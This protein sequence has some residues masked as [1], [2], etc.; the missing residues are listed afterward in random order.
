MSEQVVNIMKRG[1]FCKL[2]GLDL[3]ERDLPLVEY[4]SKS[5]L[6]SDKLSCAPCVV[7]GEHVAY[8]KVCASENLWNRNSRH[9]LD[10]AAFGGSLCLREH[11]QARNQHNSVLWKA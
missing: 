8:G 7:P 1:I 4:C 10:P 5:G 11:G 2:T 6:F 3:H 9:Q